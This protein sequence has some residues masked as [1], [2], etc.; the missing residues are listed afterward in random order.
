MSK[1]SIGNKGEELAIEYLIENN[2]RILE[3]N[4]RSKIGE[5]DIVAKINEIV[6]FVEVKTR[7]SLEYGYP[8]EAVGRT[9]K[10]KIAKTAN[11]YIMMRNLKE[12][13]FRFDIIEVYFNREKNINHFIDAFWI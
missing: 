8:Y 13:Q 5:I 2:Y 10:H 3:K 11:S 12:T 1:I 4:F 7:S 9:K 6:V